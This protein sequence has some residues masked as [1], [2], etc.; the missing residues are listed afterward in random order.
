LW[1]W[2][3]GAQPS[4]ILAPRPPA[5][6]DPPAI[7]DAVCSARASTSPPLPAAPTASSASYDFT[8]PVAPESIVATFGTNLATATAVTANPQWDTT[9]AGLQVRVRDSLNVERVAPLYYVSPTQVMYLIPKGTAPGTATIILGA[10]QSTVEVAATSPGLYTANQRGTGVAA[11]TY[12]R[13]TARGERTEALLDRG[14]PAAAGDQLYLTLYGTGMRG[15]PATATV[16][17]VSVPIAGPVAQPQYP[18]LDQI[19]LGP[20]PLRIGYGTKTITIRQG[21]RVANTVQVNF[22]VP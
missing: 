20:L 21:D 1:N 7:D 15:G 9:L 14:V 8:A 10:Q 13:I 4:T 16:G 2:M 3:T 19:N 12:I 6:P 11:G 22:R 17:D 5:T 18:G